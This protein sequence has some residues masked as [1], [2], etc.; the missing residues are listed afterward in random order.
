M[1]EIEVKIR[2]DDPKAA[3]ASILA[4]GAAVARD[5]HLETSVLYDF[6]PPVLGASRRVLRLRTAGRRATL[7]YKGEPR[8]SRS[9]KVREEHETQVRDPKAARRILSALGLK[10]VFRYRVHRTVFQ[11]S[12]LTICVDETAAGSF[13]EL[14]GERHEIVRFARSLGFGR[15]DFI[16]R[17]YVEL[18][19]DRGGGSGPDRGGDVRP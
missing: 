3:R 4:L 12:R 11:K 15:T 7:T 16:T 13:I 18:L 17:S 19:G 1:T 9:F 5:R 14:E 2:I 10:E 6:A 8:K